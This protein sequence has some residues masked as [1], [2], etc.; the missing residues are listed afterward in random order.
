MVV[1]LEEQKKKVELQKKRIKLK[2]I[3]IR[4]QER[5]RKFKRF[6]EVVKIA[7]KAHIDQLD[8]VALL[9]AFLE[10]ASKMQDEKIIREWKKSGEIFQSEHEEKHLTPLAISF[11][12]DPKKETKERLKERQ[13][14]WNAFRKEYCGYGNQKEIE[15]FLKDENCTVEIIS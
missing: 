10:I 13:F 1:D 15:I 14:R 4:E 3:L 5:Q 2:E 9:G 7:F 6:E 11:S 12:S 8:E